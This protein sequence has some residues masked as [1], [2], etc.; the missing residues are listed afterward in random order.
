[1]GGMGVG[2]E[3]MPAVKRLRMR[4]DGVVSKKSVGAAR[5]AAKSFSW[6]CLDARTPITTIVRIERR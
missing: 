6:R 2:E 1:M 3:I 5:M 4:P